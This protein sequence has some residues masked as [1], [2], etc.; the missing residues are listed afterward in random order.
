[1]ETLIEFVGMLASLKRAPGD[2]RK[3]AMFKNLL[4]TLAAIL[5]IFAGL[6][7]LAFAIFG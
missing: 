2:Q 4:A 5:V 1:M 3:H 7:L 6:P